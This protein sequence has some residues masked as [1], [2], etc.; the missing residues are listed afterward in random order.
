MSLTYS[1]YRV[2][3]TKGNWVAA[4]FNDKERAEKWIQNFD[5]KFYDDKTLTKSDFIIQ[6]SNDFKNWI[7]FLPIRRDI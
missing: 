2:Y 3:C 6:R 1:N 5:G 4:L 7:T